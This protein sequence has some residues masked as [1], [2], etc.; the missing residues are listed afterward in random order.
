MEIRGDPDWRRTP[1]VA[2][3]GQ[4]RGIEK[5]RNLIKPPTEP[6][7]LLRTGA[8]AFI[9]DPRKQIRRADQ[10]GSTVFARSCTSFQIRRPAVF[11]AV[12]AMPTAKA[13]RMKSSCGMP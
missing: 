13:W 9:V 1:H 10:K 2:K 7:D 11:M 3:T 12:C 8:V 6:K 5:K 4:N